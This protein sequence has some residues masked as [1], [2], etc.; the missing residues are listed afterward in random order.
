LTAERA[1]ITKNTSFLP[2]DVELAVR[3]LRL[4][5]MA[6]YGYLVGYSSPQS[7]AGQQEPV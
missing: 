6:I 2:D 7:K 1:I 4:P 5:A 3:R